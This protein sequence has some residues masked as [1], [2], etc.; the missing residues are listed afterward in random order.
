MSGDHAQ[1]CLAVD[2]QILYDLFVRYVEPTDLSLTKCIIC[3]CVANPYERL[4]RMEC[5]K[6]TKFHFSCWFDVPLGRNRTVGDVNREVE[7]AEKI[8][9]RKRCPTCQKEDAFAVEC[10]EHFESVS[11]VYVFCKVCEEQCTFVNWF[12]HWQTCGGALV[13]LCVKND[14]EACQTTV[15]VCGP[16]FLQVIVRTKQILFVLFI[17]ALGFCLASAVI[18]SF[19]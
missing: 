4:L 3:L 7:S 19:L 11:K 14:V 8:P 9:L 18:R 5:C 17:L 2:L 16:Q 6:A 13:R 1:T 10:K 15:S 12:P